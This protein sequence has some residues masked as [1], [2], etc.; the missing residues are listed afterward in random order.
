CDVICRSKAFLLF[1][2]KDLLLTMR[3]SAMQHS[4]RQLACLPTASG[5]LPRLAANRLRRAATTL[6][7]LLSLAG[8]TIDE[9]DHPEQRIYANKQIALLEIAAEALN[10]Q[11]LGFGLAEEF[12]CR[13]LG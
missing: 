10:D 6:E 3:R 9:S 7:T 13:D 12:D 2:A 5:G 4:I 11:C 1:L 8:L